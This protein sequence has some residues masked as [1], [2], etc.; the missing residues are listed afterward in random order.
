MMKNIYAIR[1]IVVSIGA[2]LILIWAFFNN[3]I[4][5]KIIISPFLICSLAIF[6]ENLFLI[7]KKEKLAKVFKDIFQISFFVYAFGFLGYAIYY[8]IIN[9]S[10]S[11]FIVI[12]IFLVGTIYFLKMVFFKNKKR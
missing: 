11:L 9:K 12:D 10:Y 4:L 7:F 8:A 2:F 5:G 1:Q 6:G 3:E